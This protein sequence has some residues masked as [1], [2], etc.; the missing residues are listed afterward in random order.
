MKEAK[1]LSFEKVIIL[2]T[3]IQ[4]LNTPKKTRNKKP[5]FHHLTLC[6]N[7]ENLNDPKKEAF[8][9]ILSGSKKKCG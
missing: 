4:L 8:R 1:Y 7:I 2:I 9:K 6:N 5:N 3:Q